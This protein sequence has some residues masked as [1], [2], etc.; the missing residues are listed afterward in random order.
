MCAITA[1]WA[2]RPPQ[3]PSNAT[4]RWRLT[5]RALLQQETLTQQGGSIERWNRE[6]ARGTTYNLPAGVNLRLKH[7]S[8]RGSND[9]AEWRIL[10][11]FLYTDSVPLAVQ[12]NVSSDVTVNLLANSL[13]VRTSFR[14]GLRRRQVPTVAQPLVMPSPVPSCASTAIHR[15]LHPHQDR[16][17]TVTLAVNGEHLQ[18]HGCRHGRAT[19]WA[20]NALPVAPL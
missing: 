19:R 20:T 7:Q 12:R 18:R 8:A 16:A 10:E 3:P 9:R 1:R 5:R 17:D 11:G 13:S 15:C 2:A 4:R 6:D 14:P